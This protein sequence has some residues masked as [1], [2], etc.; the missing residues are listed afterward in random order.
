MTNRGAPKG[1]Q[2]ASKGRETHFHVGT[3]FALKGVAKL[4]AGPDGLS[5]YINNLVRNDIKQNR[6]DLVDRF[7][8]AFRIE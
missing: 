4:A 1:N 2:N 8:E 3:S 5:E 6:P 7:P